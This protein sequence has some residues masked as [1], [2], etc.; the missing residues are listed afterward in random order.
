MNKIKKIIQ[1]KINYNKILSIYHK[2]L[3][4]NNKIIK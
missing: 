2:K 4:N 3:I 1:V